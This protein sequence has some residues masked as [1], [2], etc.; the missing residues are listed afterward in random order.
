[1]LSNAPHI[2]REQ[3]DDSY[4]KGQLTIF[5][6]NLGNIDTLRVK[7]KIEDFTNADCNRL[8]IGTQQQQ[9]VIVE[10]K[11]SKCHNIYYC[12][13]E[14]FI[15]KDDDD[16]NAYLS[17]MIF[18]LKYTGT[19]QLPEQKIKLLITGKTYNAYHI[20]DKVTAINGGNNYLKSFH[21]DKKDGLIRYE[22]YDGEVFEFYKLI[23]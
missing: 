20:I 14:L 17:I 13:G 11:P 3:L 16:K 6:S 4:K 12:E 22:S 9:Y 8:E 2:R 21:W 5:K 19:S 10:F 7:N 23:K 1:M 15:Q 18:G